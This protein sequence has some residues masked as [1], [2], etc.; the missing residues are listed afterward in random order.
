MNE[1]IV[2]NIGS[3]YRGN[4]DTE[5]LRVYNEYVEQST[6]D[7]GRAAGESVTW[8]VNDEPFREYIGTIDAKDYMESDNESD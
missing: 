1:I 7:Y 3:V 6:T 4:N 5:A 2:G 8:F